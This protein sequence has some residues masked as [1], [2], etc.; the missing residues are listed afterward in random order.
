MLRTEVH[1]AQCGGHLGHGFGPQLG[2]DGEL[3]G[4]G[5]D[6]QAHGAAAR[7]RRSRQYLEWPRRVRRSV[8]S[9][10]Q[11][12]AQSVQTDRNRFLER[13]QLGAER[14]AFFTQRDRFSEA[15]GDDQLFLTNINLNSTKLE[16]ARDVQIVLGSNS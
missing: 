9:D 12:S 16:M 1:C 7:W 4:D 11:S 2:R 15:A 3:G 8:Q 13:H 6:R 10:W 14:E 5:T